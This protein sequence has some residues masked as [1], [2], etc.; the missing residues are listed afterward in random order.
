MPRFEPATSVMPC[1]CSAQ[2]TTDISWLPAGRL[3]PFAVYLHVLVTVKNPNT[4]KTHNFSFPRAKNHTNLFH[5][6]VSATAHLFHGPVWARTGNCTV[7]CP[8]NHVTKL[9]CFVLKVQATA[10]HTKAALKTLFFSHGVCD[11]GKYFLQEIP[12]NTL[13]MRKRQVHKC[14][15]TDVTTKETEAASVQWLA[16]TWHVACFFLGGT[17]EIFYG[18]KSS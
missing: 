8:G 13:K 2:W 9:Q 12:K 10:K 16:W 11:S 3:V 6:T 1:P 18:K 15:T 5:G 17:G 7:S 4:V 14:T